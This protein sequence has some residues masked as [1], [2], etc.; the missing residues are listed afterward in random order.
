MSILIELLPCGPLTVTFS[1]FI[2]FEEIFKVNSAV[3]LYNVLDI[4]EQFA[5]SLSLLFV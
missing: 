4:S 5:D 1:D 3:Q 2:L